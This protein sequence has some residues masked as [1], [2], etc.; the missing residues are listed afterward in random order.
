MKRLQI[1]ATTANMGP[2]FDCMGMAFDFYNY[3]DF[4]PTDTIGECILTADGSAGK[5]DLSK[6]NLIYQ[7]YEAVFRH[8]G[9]EPMGI[10]MH[11][12]N[13]IPYSRGL[14]SSSAA[15]IGG[16]K[17]AND[18]MGN[19][20]SDRELLEIAIPFEGHPD[21]LAPALLGGIIISGILEDGKIFYSK[22]EAP[23]GL[24]C[25]VLIPDYPLSTQKARDVLPDMIPRQDAVFNVGRV[26]MLVDALHTGNLEQ[27]ALAMEDKI[28]QPYR[29][30]LIV[31][32]E[33]I[34]PMARE[35]GA[36]GVII[37]G[38]GPT[39]LLVSDKGKDFTPL[40]KFLKT[41]G[42][43]ARLKVVRPVND[44]AEI[45]EQW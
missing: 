10:R 32:M 20:L 28:H 4:E 19:P 12:V 40:V 11:F 1:P 25:T 31:G 21:N 41:K 6:N 15:L 22:I 23:K 7:A 44:G 8:M 17:V 39:L 30:S 29:Q 34:V 38:A 26:A 27:L 3:I 2:G 13:E 14:G 45:T 37:S 18:V 42:V 43:N 33:E 24:V 36:W 9:K 16:V 5:I 35:L